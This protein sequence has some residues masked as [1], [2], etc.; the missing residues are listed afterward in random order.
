METYHYT[1]TTKSFHSAVRVVWY[2]MDVIQ[3]LLLFR[4]FLKFLGANPYAPFT[5][6]IYQLTYSFASPF[7]N[8]FR[9]TPVGGGGVLEWGAILAMFVYYIIALGIVRI[10]LVDKVS[11][12]SSPTVVKK[13]TI[14]EEN[15]NEHL[16]T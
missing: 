11:T 13:T 12:I 4:L 10:F 9:P 5:N 15:K 16:H 3:V 8:V 7:L 14:V 2:I 1:T 6:F